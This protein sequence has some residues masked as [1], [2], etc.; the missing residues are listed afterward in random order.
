[1]RVPEGTIGQKQPHDSPAE[2]NREFLW[3]RLRKY[4]QVDQEHPAGAKA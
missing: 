2:R 4:R 3:N 1:M